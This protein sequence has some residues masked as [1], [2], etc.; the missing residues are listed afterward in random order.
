MRNWL[1][2]AVLAVSSLFAFTPTADAHWGY[3]G[4]RGGYYSGYRGHYHTPHYHYTPSY[5]GYYYGYPGG[6]YYYRAPTYGYHYH[7]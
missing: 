6:G 1:I 4:Y 3:G 5:R 7:W 2:A